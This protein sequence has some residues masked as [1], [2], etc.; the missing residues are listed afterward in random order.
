MFKKK[1]ITSKNEIREIA[2]AEAERALRRHVAEERT[3]ERQ[4]RHSEQQ[5]VLLQRRIKVAVDKGLDEFLEQ[6]AA[7]ARRDAGSEVNSALVV[8]R[9]SEQGNLATVSIE[10]RHSPLPLS[11]VTL[12]AANLRRFLALIDREIVDTAILCKCETH[13]LNREREEMHGGCK[14]PNV[15]VPV[16]PEWERFV[17]SSV[18]VADGGRD[19]FF[20]RG[21]HNASPVCS[22]PSAGHTCSPAS[23]VSENTSAGAV[24]PSAPAH[25]RF[26]AVGEYVYD[27]EAHRVAAFMDGSKAHEVA[28]RMNRPASDFDGYMWEDAK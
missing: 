13:F 24:S 4:K 22:G 28:D 17:D 8:T 18:A 3:T 25:P 19:H 2:K 23:T 16:F 12:L 7:S 21:T 26:V 9:E 6:A 20:S 10:L 15:V 11:E 27:R 14:L 5:E 1:R